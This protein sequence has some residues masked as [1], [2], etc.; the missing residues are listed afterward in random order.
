MQLKIKYFSVIIII[1]SSGSSSGCSIGNLLYAAFLSFF[2][3]PHSLVAV[4]EK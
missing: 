3:P 1:I 2:S 4:E